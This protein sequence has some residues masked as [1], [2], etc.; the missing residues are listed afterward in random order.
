M[1]Q[2]Y[3]NGYI[4]G[5]N[6]ESY[7]IYNACKLGKTNNIPERDSTYATGEI[8]R[9]YFEPVFEISNKNT[10]IIECEL[11]DEFKEFNIFINSGKEFYDTKIINLIEPYFI[12]NGVQYR[13]LTKNEI[14]SLIRTYRLKP[15]LKKIDI[16]CLINVLKTTIYIPRDYQNDIIKKSIIY[17]KKHDK[18]LLVLMCGVGK[19]LISLWIT[20]KLRSNTL[21]IGVPNKVLLQ[22]WETVIKILFKKP[23]LIVSGGVST[24]HIKRFIQSNQENCILITTY[25]SSHKVHEATTDTGFSFSMKILDEA[26]HLTTFNMEAKN[27]TKR[28]IEMLKI[29]SFKQIALTATL[30]Q[31]EG[32]GDDLNIVSNE[33]TEYFG[34]IIEK[35]GLLWSINKNIICDYVIQTI[36]TEEEKMEEQLTRFNIVEENDKRLFLSSYASLKSI[37]EGNSH[38]LLLYSNNKVS[39]EK[40]IRYI[41]LLLENEYFDIPDLYYYCYNGSM[42]NKQRDE[43]LKIFNNSKYGIISC[44]YCLGEGYNNTNIDAVVFSEN[45][46]SEIRIVQSSLRACRKDKNHPDKVSKIILPV[47]NNDNWLE[48][49]DNV[50][51]KKV[52]E[53]IYQMG[54]E[55]ET[56]TQKIKVSRIDIEKQKTKQKKILPGVREVDDEFGEYDDELTQKLRLKT[57]KR[58]TLG[59]TYEK[60]RKIISNKNITSKEEY[61]ELCDRDNRLTKEPER[62]FKGQFTN[63]IDYLSIERVYYDF[64]TCKSKVNEYITSTPGIKKD[65]MDLSIIT[66]KL[67]KM[68]E[69]F[70]PCGLWTEYYNVKDLQ[71]I[72]DVIETP[73]KKRSTIIN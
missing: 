18:G 38:H 11:Q 3:E 66:D 8:R 67:C 53:V 72:I 10:D 13:K 71:D 32:N 44:V 59:T 51:L 56:I 68:D 5:R 64:K 15:I 7:E 42:R 24:G 20:Q 16:Q 23:C 60:A 55:D 19:T 61:Y 62:V 69:L 49:N 26:H 31:L 29:K 46:S 52:R 28:Y 2:P 6:H 9:G 30:K 50:D 25:S 39:S 70:P 12:K 48:N 73:K 17:F 54:L 14:N 47:L 41:K 35:L 1:N 65:Y 36:I 37:F 22:Q 4:Y 58:T 21:I 45:M 34:E 40:L 33:N 43:I 63:W 27:N 57:I